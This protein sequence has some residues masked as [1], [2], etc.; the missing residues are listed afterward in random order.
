MQY[1]IQAATSGS[2]RVAATW[3]QR[4][5]RNQTSVHL[6]SYIFERYIARKTTTDS[7]PLIEYNQHNAAYCETLYNL[8][9]AIILA[10]ASVRY[11]NLAYVRYKRD[12]Q[13][14]VNNEE[15]WSGD[16]KAR[17]KMKARN[18]VSKN[19]VF[20]PKF[21]VL[22]HFSIFLTIDV[23]SRVCLTLS[24]VSRLP[25]QRGSFFDICTCI[26]Y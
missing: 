4:V 6:R 23:I 13:V 15:N 3:R 24:P 12:A 17:K 2:K 10:D 16:G 25:T 18:E 20:S 26:N 8:T 1:E 5:G 22:F 7:D 19:E 14:N 11:T 21:L 9:K